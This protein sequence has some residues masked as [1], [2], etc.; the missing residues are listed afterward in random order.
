MQNHI[1]ASHAARHVAIHCFRTWAPWLGLALSLC[2]ANAWAGQ[3]GVSPFGAPVV[4][5]HVA[6]RRQIVDQAHGVSQV[7]DTPAP[8]IRVQRQLESISSEQSSGAEVVTL[9]WRKHG[10]YAIPIRVGMF[11]TLS[12]PEDSPI[13]QVAFTNKAALQVSVIPA[14]N[15]IMVRLM[16]PISVPGAIVTRK[17]IY[18]VTITPSDSLWYQGVYW[19]NDTQGA[20]PESMAADYVS[21]AAASAPAAVNPASPLEAALGG[22]PNFDY[23]MHGHADFKPM[24]VWDNGR[25]TWIQF[26]KNVQELPAVFIKDRNGLSIVNY[27]VHDHGTQILVNRLMPEFVLRVGREDIT[28]KAGDRR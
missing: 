11:S 5:T 10:T 16:Q 19:R 9:D 6:P 23:R 24:A 7:V 21:P 17:R 2:M 27:T 26:A 1:A 12:L 18:Y 15:A 3:G 25:F 28:V 13:V 22:Q 8:V 4:R 20:M 14:T